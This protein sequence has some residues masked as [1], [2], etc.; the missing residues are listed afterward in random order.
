MGPVKLALCALQVGE[1]CAREKLKRGSTEEKRRGGG[2]G[3]VR[4]KR[5]GASPGLQT[6][7]VA[8]S[9]VNTS[10]LLWANQR[11]EANF[12]SRGKGAWTGH[13]LGLPLI[14][15]RP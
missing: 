4:E 2:G 15:G 7:R 9:F 10:R 14:S 6:S 5:G 1:A 3:E 8:G 11:V 12:G 13:M